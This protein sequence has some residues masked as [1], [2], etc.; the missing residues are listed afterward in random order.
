MTDDGV[1]LEKLLN[2]NSQREFCAP[3]TSFDWNEINTRRI[4][5][6]SIDTTCTIWDLER[7]CVDTQLIAHDREVRCW[8]LA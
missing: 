5:T 1:R 8:H 7:G 6:A 4:G 3:L 2:N